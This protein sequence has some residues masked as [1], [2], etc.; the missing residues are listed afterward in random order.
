MTKRRGWN[1]S[2]VIVERRKI[3]PGRRERKAPP[4]SAKRAEKRENGP[5]AT[6]VS[7]SLYGSPIVFPDKLR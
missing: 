7:K 3:E 6:E 2:E 4:S 1:R 5:L